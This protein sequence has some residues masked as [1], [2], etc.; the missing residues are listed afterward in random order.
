MK[1]GYLIERDLFKN[2][3]STKEKNNNKTSKIR[4]FILG[5]LKN[6]FV[7]KI[8]SKDKSNLKTISYDIKTDKD[9]NLRFLF[10][11]DLHLEIHDNTSKI[12]EVLRNE[13]KF[14]FIVFGGD[15]FDN[16]KNAFLEKE[17]WNNLISFLKTKTSA[18][19]AV[20]GN[21]DG[22]KTIKLIS[23]DLNLLLN[24]SFDLEKA[25]LYGVEDYVTFKNTKDFLKIDETK[26]NILISHTPDFIDEVE[27]NYDLMLSGHTHGGQI[28]ICGY[29][30]VKHCKYKNLFY[31]KWNKKGITGI[32]TSGVGC[33]GY[34]YRL[35]VNPEIVV[36]N[37]FKAPHLL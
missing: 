30:P 26:F 33:S 18:I 9:V 28:S 14:D 10:L 32:T 29:K 2:A 34:P 20:L 21:H 5:K 27:N 36:V 7:K 16:D 19:F 8:L 24:D 31:G 35:G 4:N 11:S 17:K 15:F 13:P 22:D 37:I 3:P 1:N 25:S 23:S 6:D 12:K